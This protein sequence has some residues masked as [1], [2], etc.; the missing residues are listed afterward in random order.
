[1]DRGYAQGAGVRHGGKGSGFYVASCSG[2]DSSGAVL[3]SVVRLLQRVGQGFKACPVG[4][5]DQAHRPPG[6]SGDRDDRD[7][8]RRAPDPS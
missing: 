5:D 1:M 6:P 3:Q 4:R 2:T 8:G 7:L